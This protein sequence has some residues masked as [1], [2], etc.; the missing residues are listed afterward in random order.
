MSPLNRTASL[1]PGELLMANMGVVCRKTGGA[2]GSVASLVEFDRLPIV[3]HY[4]LS[5][6]LPAYPV[7]WLESEAESFDHMRITVPIIG[8]IRDLATSPETRGRS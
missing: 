7:A 6:E 8:N 1:F 5:A 2:P 4:F 3:I